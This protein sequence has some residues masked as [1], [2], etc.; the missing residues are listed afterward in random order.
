[1]KPGDLVKI[2]RRAIGVPANTIGLITK[3]E[4]SLGPELKLLYYSVLICRKD[5]SIVER[6]YLREDLRPV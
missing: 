2:T 3:V 1:M 5:K 4:S 6:R